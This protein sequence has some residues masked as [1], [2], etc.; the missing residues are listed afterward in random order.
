MSGVWVNIA[1][2]PW[3]EDMEPPLRPFRIQRLTGHLADVGEVLLGD[4]KDAFGVVGAGDLFGQI[5]LVVAASVQPS[6]SSN[7]V[8]LVE[9]AAEIDGARRLAN[10]W[11]PSCRPCRP[12]ARRTTRAADRAS[13]DCRRSRD[14]VR[15]RTDDPP[16]SAALMPASNSSSQVSGNALDPGLLEPVDRYS[17]A[18]RYCRTEWLSICR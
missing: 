18:G 13:R 4:V 3:R 11:P 10:R 12:P 14:R 6:T 9:F 2:A 1:V 7:I 5:R 8:C 16:S 15:S 17:S